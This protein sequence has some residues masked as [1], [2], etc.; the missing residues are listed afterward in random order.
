MKEST[1]TKLTGSWRHYS[2]IFR[3]LAREAIPAIDE[4][5]QDAAF[6]SGQTK[7]APANTTQPVYVFEHAF[8]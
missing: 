3:R 1:A 7:I 4:S 8:I 6:T 2:E 5:C